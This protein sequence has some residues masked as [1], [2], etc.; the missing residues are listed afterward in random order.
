MKLQVQ[1][2]AL[3]RGESPEEE[4][5][6]VQEQKRKEEEEKRNPNNWPKHM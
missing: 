2:D 5:K 3:R 4:W 1:K 6:R